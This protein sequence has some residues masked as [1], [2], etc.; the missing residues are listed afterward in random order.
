MAL[1]SDLSPIFV[2]V[3]R[4][5]LTG[6]QQDIQTYLR[7]TVK[8]LRANHPELAG[9]L[10]ALLAA[11][12]NASSPLRDAGAAFV[13]MDSDSRLALVRHEHPI[14]IEAEPVLSADIRTKLDQVIQERRNLAALRR[15]GLAPAR[16]LLFAGPPGVG[17][18]LSARWLARELERPLLTLDLAT[19]MSSYLGKTGS[20]V[21]AVLDYA[22]TVPCVLLL[23]EFDAIA[24]RRDDD[25]D[26]G[27]LRRLVTVIL[28]EVDDWP[29]D[30]LLIA[31]TNHGDLLDPA[32]WRRFDE[33]IDFRLPDAALMT[34]AVSRG[35][36]GD[37]ETSAAWVP[38][39]SR[40]WAGRSFSDVERGLNWCRRRSVVAEEPLVESLAEYIREDLGRAPLAIRRDAALTLDEAGLP[41]RRIYQ[42]TG[43]ARDTLRKYRR[44]K[45]QRSG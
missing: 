19:V 5:A 31:A 12:P 33:V 35:L 38:V 8:G 13:P 43:V 15:E 26:I 34:I 1:P 25:S 36:G 4:L 24:K 3:S 28:Q 23:D 32:V 37:D 17:K 21:R 18:T 2:Q 22:K 40:L 27:E 9:E 7:R 11:S 20:N 16:A 41:E 10:S 39:L 45:N 29:A 6:R 14:L 42:L 30:N 44:Q